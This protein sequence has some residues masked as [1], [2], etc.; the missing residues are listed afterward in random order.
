MAGELTPDRLRRVYDPDSIGFETTVGL[1]AP[2]EIIGQP[3][4]T[5][6]LQFGLGMADSGYHIYIA[7]PR[8]TGKM[9]TVNAFLADAA[10][11]RPVPDDLCYVFNFA[12]PD[13]P[14]ALR[15]PPG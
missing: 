9:T 11:R 6:A 8:G 7:G 12:D 4:A 2:A 15:L 3:R 1:S 14:R 13:Q 5:A 10:L